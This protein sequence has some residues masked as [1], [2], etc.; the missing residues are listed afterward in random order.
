M[1]LGIAETIVGV[2]GIVLSVSIFSVLRH[3][4][5][6]PVRNTKKLLNLIA[7]LA[8]KMIKLYVLIV[9]LI[10]VFVRS[11]ICLFSSNNTAKLKSGVR[12]IFSN[13]I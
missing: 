8:P 4:V 2:S 3:L 9:V 6:S 12:L 7:R 1:F 10:C 5:I 11:Y 13:H